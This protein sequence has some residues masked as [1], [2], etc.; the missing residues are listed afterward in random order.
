MTGGFRAGVVGL[1]YFGTFHAKH[2]AAHPG[3]TLTALVDVDE[4]RAKA[5]AEQYG[6]EPLTDYRDLIGRVDVASVA[7]PTS[8]HFEVA[9]ALLSA[10]IH[11]L[12]EKPIT[13]TVDRAQALVDC[14]G[15]RG[16]VL[17]VGHIERFSAV[18]RALAAKVTR[19]LFI[20]AT[21]ISPFRPRAID[22]DVV[23]DLMIHDIDIVLGLAASE[24]VSVHAVGVPVLTAGE[25]IANARIEFASGAVANITASRIAE[26]TERRM[27]VFQPDSYVVCDFDASRIELHERAGDPALLGAAAIGAKSW[28]VSKEDSLFNEISEFLD[29]VRSGRVPTVDGRVGREA[30]RV[31][32]MITENLRARRRRIEAELVE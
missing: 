18:Y 26:T 17:Q 31:A 24:I 14:A 13:D 20:E 30:L 2:Y 9:H 8:R 19:P 27:R 11:V 6:G 15:E 7:V 22:V 12:V 21:R 32:N 29:C 16:L 28:N 3:A 23:L 5:A 10:G 1:G 25:D 4:G